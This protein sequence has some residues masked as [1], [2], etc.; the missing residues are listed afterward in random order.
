MNRL[1]LAVIGFGQ[2]G[3]AC[4]KAIL[5]DEQTV[6]S[7]IVRRPASLVPKREPRFEDIVMASHI[8]ELGPVDCALICVPPEQVIGVAH[9]LIQRDIPVVE[10][11]RLHGEAFAEHKKEIDRLVSHHKGTAIVG[12]G[13][14]PGILSVIRGLFALVTPHGHTEVS[15]RPGVTLHHTTVAAA[16]PG[17]KGAL[18]T[19]LRTSDGKSQRYVY[20]EVEEG[21]D[22]ARVER[23]IRQD[24]LF[25]G[26]ETFVFPVPNIR[27]LEEEGNGIL[28]ERRGATADAEHQL[29]LLE[30]RFS[31]SALAART[32]ISAARTTPRAHHRAYSLFDLPLGGL[33]GELREWAEKENI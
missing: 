31:E 32:M 3:R 7:G 25:L 15:W 23:E 10:C 19:E 26:A 17:L 22:F 16:V 13:W 14:D 28:L 5:D 2:L 12:A 21:A 1:R 18:S 8:S 11:A 33:W 6:L 20:I 30:A 27:Q 4:A 9:D 24:P 29:L